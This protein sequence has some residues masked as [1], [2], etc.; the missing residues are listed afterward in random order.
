MKNT[1][2][3]YG[4]ISSRNSE[5]VRYIGKTVQSLNE[6]LNGHIR[7]RMSEKNHKVNWIRREL[8]NGYKIKIIKIDEVWEVDWKFW[9]IFWIY[10]YKKLGYNL[11][12]GSNGGDNNENNVP[13]IVLSINGK[14]LNRFNSI[15]AAARHYKLKER[16]VANNVRG[17]VSRLGKRIFINEE[18]YDEN[19]NYAIDTSIRENRLKTIYQFTLNGEFIKEWKGISIAAKS[20]GLSP[21]VISAALNKVQQSSGGYMWSYSSENPQSIV[22]E[23]VLRQYNKSNGI[24]KV[25]NNGNYVGTCNSPKE[26]SEKYNIPVKNVYRVLCKDVKSTAGGYTFIRET[27]GV[28]I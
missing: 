11:V 6:R 3:I 4:L 28:L 9:E 5:D 1:A 22:N 8:R 13:I 2:I 21:C 18:S 15:G 17:Q 27:D 12:N 26:I 14:F 25:Y 16:S 19:K 10:Q 24:I 7:T 23:N 20:I